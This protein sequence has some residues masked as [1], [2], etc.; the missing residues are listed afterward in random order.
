MRGIPSPEVKAA[1]VLWKLYPHHEGFVRRLPWCWSAEV[2]ETG[3][4][5]PPY[6]TQVIAEGATAKEL[7]ARL[8]ELEAGAR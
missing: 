4:I 5:G 1:R 7:L 2:V 3:Q 8:L 6:R